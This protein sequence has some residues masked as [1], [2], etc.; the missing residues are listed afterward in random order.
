MSFINRQYQIF[1]Q[2]V[3]ITE[4]LIDMDKSTKRKLAT[5]AANVPAP[6]INDPVEK[7]VKRQSARRKLIA[8][9][10][11][12]DPVE[13]SVKRQS[14]TPPIL[15]TGELLSE[16]KGG[17]SRKSKSR[18]SKSIKSKSRKSKSRKSKSRKSKSGKS[19]S[20]KSIK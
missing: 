18:K 6:Q 20:R 17:K 16:F 11:L 15:S 9:P 8:K 2:Q 3:R 4:Y 13:K 10:P 14:A 5:N 19:K 1:D 12:K 7:S